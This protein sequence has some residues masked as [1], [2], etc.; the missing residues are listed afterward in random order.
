MWHTVC[1][2]LKITIFGEKKKMVYAIALMLL[3]FRFCFVRISDS[4]Q[5]ICEV[6][7]KKFWW[8]KKLDVKI[9]NVALFG[10][11]Q[12]NNEHSPKRLEKKWQ[13]LARW[14]KIHNTWDTYWDRLSW[15]TWVVILY[16][17]EKWEYMRCLRV[18]VLH[19]FCNLM[20]CMKIF[21]FFFAQHFLVHIL[22][23]NDKLV[24]Q[25]VECWCEL[26]PIKSKYMHFWAF[27]DC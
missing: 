22:Q 21:S 12:S 19:M 2:T 5:M 16:R 8:A 14:K 13:K 9:K 11:R 23:R 7:M 3:I 18:S 1:L 24:T 20:A 26:R 25:N 17:T 27:V 6:K 10:Q 15:L 4:L